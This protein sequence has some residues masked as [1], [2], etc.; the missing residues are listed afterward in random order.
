MHHPWAVGSNHTAQPHWYW[1]KQQSCLPCQ[2]N[3]S[4]AVAGGGCSLFGAGMAHIVLDVGALGCLTR[5]FPMVTFLF[6]LFRQLFLAAEEV[7]SVE[8]YS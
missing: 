8:E 3:I 7:K 1:D 2:G 5:A 4:Q 6:L